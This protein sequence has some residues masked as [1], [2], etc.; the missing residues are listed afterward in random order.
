MSPN[1]SR[2]QSFSI[3]KIQTPI[4]HRKPDSDPPPSDTLSRVEMA[5]A[6]AAVLASGRGKPV[7]GYLSGALNR[8]LLATIPAELLQAHGARVAGRIESG[9][10]G[11]A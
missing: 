2:L 9:L 6:A 4:R 11:N 10:V 1:L 3:W 8:A 5:I 7:P